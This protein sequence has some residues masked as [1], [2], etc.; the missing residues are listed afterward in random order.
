MAATVTTRRVRVRVSGTVQGVGF[1]PFVYRLADELGLGGWV[2]NDSLGVLIEVEG[3]PL[4]VSDFL[5]RLADEAPPLASVDGVVPEELSRDRRAR[6][7]DPRER[8]RGE[9]AAPVSPDS[10]TCEECLAE[11]LDPADRRYRY[12]FINCTNCGPRF[13]IVKGVPYDRRAD[14][15]GRDSRCARRAEP[16]TRT[17]ST[18][19]ST[20]SRTPARPAVRG[21]GSTSAAGGDADLGDSPDAVAAAAAA[22][23]AGAIVAVKGLGGYHLACRADDAEGRSRRCA[24]ASTERTS[25]SR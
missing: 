14:D 22:L 25:R 13:T 11:L 1:R 5:E 2:L 21:L 19:A 9:P 24:R 8:G 20:P 10:A 15:D 6:V 3:V 7:P 12:P 17:R 4:A 16:S 23:V 18:A